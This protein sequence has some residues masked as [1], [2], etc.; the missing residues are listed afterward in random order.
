MSKETH[1]F[2]D[3]DSLFVHLQL[4]RRPGDCFKVTQM[5]RAC[6]QTNVLEI[7]DINYEQV[8]VKT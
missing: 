4:D 6:P 5:L 7:K 1:L 3:R 8:I 2:P